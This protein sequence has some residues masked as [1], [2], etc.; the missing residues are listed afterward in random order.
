MIFCVKTVTR[1]ETRKQ[2]GKSQARDLEVSSLV[3]AI[4]RKVRQTL[5]AS[6]DSMCL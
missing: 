2:G 1:K 5:T 6:V 3:E 4:R